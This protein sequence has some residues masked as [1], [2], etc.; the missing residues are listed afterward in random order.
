M[1]NSF[2]NLLVRTVLGTALMGIAP[3]AF[4]QSVCLPAPRLL[5]TMPMGGKAGTQFEITISGENLDELGELDKNLQVKLLRFL[6]A[7]EIQRLGE[8]PPITVEMV[9]L[10]RP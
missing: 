10:E 2:R 1:K 8:S 3:V 9:L 6:E 4:A 7:G 5:T